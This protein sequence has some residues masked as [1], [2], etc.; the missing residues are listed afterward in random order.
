MMRYYSDLDFTSREYCDIIEKN[1]EILE[2]KYESSEIGLI[3]IIEEHFGD[4][5]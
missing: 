4:I 2:T 5:I 1:I 3:N